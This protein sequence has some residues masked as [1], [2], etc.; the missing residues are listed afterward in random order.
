MARMVIMSFLDYEWAVG[1]AISVMMIWGYIIIV[2]TARMAAF[3]SY[4]ITEDT[5]YGSPD[6]CGLGITSYCLAH[7]S[8]ASTSY[9]ESVHS[10]VPSKCCREIG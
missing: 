7:Y 8:P 2:D 4:Y 5:T 6:N 9:N 3:I 10:S 1:W